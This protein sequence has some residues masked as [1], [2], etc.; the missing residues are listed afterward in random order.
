MGD[1]S[2]TAHLVW[3]CQRWIAV[4]VRTLCLSGLAAEMLLV[5]ERQEEVL[6]SG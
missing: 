6:L 3:I 2:Q 4:L 1:G 5:H